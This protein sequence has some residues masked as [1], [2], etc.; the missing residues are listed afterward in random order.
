MNSTVVLDQ[1]AIR[2]DEPVR[3][4][5]RRKGYAVWSIPRDASVYEAIELMS[6]AKIGALVVFGGGQVVGIVSERDYARKVILQGR[7]SRSTL[8]EE[9]MSTPVW[10]VRETDTIDECMR[11]MTSR[12]VR[13]LP[14]L[15]GATAVAVVSIGDL[16]NWV[17][18]SQAQT[19]D[20][21]QRYI[22][23]AYP[24]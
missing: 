11:L 9:I 10:S 19:I 1:A 12:R 20:Y 23:G 8:V 4:V 7:D 6:E 3:A 22:D 13:H 5:L 17:V 24:G 16:V 14:V 15:D 18:G 2:F 21:L